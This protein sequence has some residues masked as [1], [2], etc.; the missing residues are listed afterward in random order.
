MLA[1][2]TRTQTPSL[3]DLQHSAEVRGAVLHTDLNIAQFKDLFSQ[4][5]SNLE[6]MDLTSAQSLF[7]NIP[8]E[9]LPKDSAGRFRTFSQA[10]SILL[11]K[12]FFEVARESGFEVQHDP[13]CSLDAPMSAGRRATQLIDQLGES[14]GTSPPIDKESL[15]NLLQPKFSTID[16]YLLVRTPTEMTN[17]ANEQVKYLKSL[18]A[19]QFT[20]YLARDSAPLM[21]LHTYLSNISGAPKSSGLI[22]HGG[23]RVQYTATTDL[24]A[25]SQEIMAE[26]AIKFLEPNNQ[27]KFRYSYW[28]KDGM[29][30][31]QE[32][33]DAQSKKGWKL[34]AE[35]EKL[36]DEAIF[37]EY[38]KIFID[39]VG[40]AFDLS[41]TI[42]DADLFKQGQR[43]FE[44]IRNTGV[45]ESN[46]KELVFCDTSGTGKTV[47]LAK[48]IYDYFSRKLELGGPTSK[49]MLLKRFS[50]YTDHGQS[51]IPGFP[52][53]FD[54]SGVKRVANS[55]SASKTKISPFNKELLAAEN[56]IQPFF[57]S[58]IAS[59]GQVELSPNSLPGQIMCLLRS[60]INWN[61]AVAQIGV[62]STSILKHTI[63]NTSQR[64]RL[65]PNLL[66][67]LMGR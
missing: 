28:T 55:K 47:L 22:Y 44:Q 60:I 16:P 67:L 41:Q 2:L 34:R 38:Q 64:F 14:L 49:V 32:E 43:L 7:L 4:H 15:K 9:L 3:A 48:A 18:A 42:K 17:I 19:D 40:K 39:K 51:R 56:D 23:L 66:D 21:Q 45:F 63:P 11:I 24:N 57:A 33:L 25:L 5:F 8:L 36:S 31:D 35:F 58:K 30:K 27:D 61:T 65:M 53:I 10:E 26:L 50:N 46:S 20:I 62:E 1:S 29:S 59:N 37:Q 54:E 12:S 6:K 13:N 52:C